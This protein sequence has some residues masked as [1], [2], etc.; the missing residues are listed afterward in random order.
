MNLTAKQLSLVRRA[1]MAYLKFGGRNGSE[2]S[3]TKVH[4]LIVVS[5]ATTFAFHKTT[6]EPD[7]QYENLRRFLYGETNSSPYKVGNIVK[8]L[9]AEGKLKQSSLD[10]ENDILNEMLAVSGSLARSDQE[11]QQLLQTLRS[12]YR[13]GKTFDGG[14]M[15]VELRVFPNPDGFTF[16]ATEISTITRDRDEDLD[17]KRFDADEN[18]HRTQ[19][20]RE[21][22]GFIST[23]KKLLFIFLRGADPDDRIFYLQPFDRYV[24]VYSDNF[25]LLRNGELMSAT[26][27]NELQDDDPV[28]LDHAFRFRH[29]E[30]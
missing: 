30:T 3:L 7:F 19:T 4:E 8:F 10:A 23:P 29:V 15:S 5:E 26:N 14:R 21:G 9:I 20:Q 11:T 6:G 16:S 17:S 18:L 13:A 25:F 1:L 12:H 22:Y 27:E 24:Y 28:S 2:L